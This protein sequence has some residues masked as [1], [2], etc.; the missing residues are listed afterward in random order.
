MR[1]VRTNPF[2]FRWPQHVFR[3]AEHF[4]THH[5]VH[6]LLDGRAGA[7][8]AEISLV[9]EIPHFASDGKYVFTHFTDY[10]DGI[11]QSLFPNW[12]EVLHIGIRLM[13]LHDSIKNA[14]NYSIR[15]N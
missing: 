5:N 11:L 9:E 3:F 6:V 13:T 1:L 7:R 8:D 15:A 4:C 2:R 10:F 14:A 12:L